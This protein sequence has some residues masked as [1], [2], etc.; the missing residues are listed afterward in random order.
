MGRPTNTTHP[1]KTPRWGGYYY[2]LVEDRYIYNK[3]PKPL[4]MLAKRH[5]N[6]A[7]LRFTASRV[8]LTFRAP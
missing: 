2:Y 4:P 8:R 6:H 7:G 3:H 1:P 5:C